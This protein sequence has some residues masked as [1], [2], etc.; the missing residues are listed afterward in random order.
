MTSRIVI[1]LAAIVVGL[2]GLFR[3]LSAPDRVDAA[4]LPAH[5]PDAG[6]G[7]ILFNEAGCGSCHGAKAAG[8][9]AN[10][11][12]GPILAG[13][14]ALETP[15]GSITVP[16][17]SPDPAHGIGAWSAA[18][19][20]TA[21]KEGVSPDGTYFTP[22]FPWTSY[23]GMTVPDI[24]DLKAYLDTLPASDNAAAATGLPFPFSWRRPIGIWKRFLLPDLPAAP[25]GASAEVERGH[26]LTVALGH[27]GECHTPRTLAFAP[28]P[29]RWLAGA[30]ALEGDGGVPNITPSADGIGDWSAADIAY[31]LESGFTPDYDSIGGSMGPIVDHWSK[32]PDAD[33]AA[34]AAYL[35]AIPALPDP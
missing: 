16:N 5:T 28:D 14:L 8:D 9:A 7:E 21:M 26:Y 34:V 29:S 30:P 20:V 33:R 18:D 27:C 32:V 6:N 2:G 12:G 4:T 24:L 15:L 11:E 31:L 13:G 23:R 22:A 35:K 25:D 10:P 3:W 1:V 19:F 17:I